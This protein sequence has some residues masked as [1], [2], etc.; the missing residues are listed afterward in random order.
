MGNSSGAVNRFGRTA[1]ASQPADG[2]RGAAAADSA[3]GRPRG[4]PR[5]PPPVPED[6]R[7]RPEEADSG[8][9]PRQVPQGERTLPPQH[10]P[11]NLA[12]SM[13]NNR[14]PDCLPFARQR[15]QSLL[16][17]LVEM[18]MQHHERL[19]AVFT[20]DAP[21]TA[22]APPPLQAAL[23]PPPATAPP[24]TAPPSIMPPTATRPPLPSTA[25]SNSAVQTCIGKAAKIPLHLSASSFQLRYH[26]NTIHC[27][28]GLLN[29][30]ESIRLSARLLN[31]K[32][33]SE[34]Q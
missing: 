4:R 24:A 17:S 30:R 10:V 11:Q 23:P 12:D 26:T 21:A 1:K 9:R 19:A 25:Q 27:E 20:S 31:S 8:S 22:P 16:D 32:L 28:T 13:P 34:K 5:R 18:L 7:A 14:T 2:K 29:K 15:K 3:A 33:A 6:S